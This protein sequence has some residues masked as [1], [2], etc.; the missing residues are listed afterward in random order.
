MHT[1]IFVRVGI[2]NKPI[3]TADFFKSAVLFLCDRIPEF[4]KSRIHTLCFRIGIR[5][6]HDIAVFRNK[7]GIPI[8]RDAVPGFHLPCHSDLF[9]GQAPRTGCYRGS[10][11]ADHN[12][13]GFQ[14]ELAAFIYPHIPGCRTCFCHRSRR[15][16]RVSGRSIFLKTGI[17]SLRGRIICCHNRIFGRV[18]VAVLF[19]VCVRMA[20]RTLTVESRSCTVCRDS[21]LEVDK[22]S[23][24]C[25]DYNIIPSLLRDCFHLAA[26]KVVNKE[27]ERHIIFGQDVGR[28]FVTYEETRNDLRS[29]GVFAVYGYNGCGCFNHFL[30]SEGCR[31]G[32]CPCAFRYYDLPS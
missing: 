24:V 21:P 32:I 16:G 30:D 13:V 6:G 3:S 9:S 17:R 12:A 1:L 26:I 22:V 19:L 20:Y 27:I 25:G 11:I 28:A 10:C 23:A 8:Q 31:Y 4:W 7:G 18:V 14:N 15:I 2:R 5:I 29:F